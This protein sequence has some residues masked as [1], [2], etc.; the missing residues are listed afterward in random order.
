[1]AEH[2]H[3]TEHHVDPRLYFIVW[4]ALLVLTGLT[5]GVSFL[6]MQRFTILRESASS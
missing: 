4:A 2:H 1:M 6:D 5:V 3:E